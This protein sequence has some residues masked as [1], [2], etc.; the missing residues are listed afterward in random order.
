MCQC[1][2]VLWEYRRDTGV[3]RSSSIWQNSRI[4]IEN[5]LD[6]KASQKGLAKGEFGTFT[7]MEKYNQLIFIECNERSQLFNKPSY[8]GY[9]VNDVDTTK[10]SS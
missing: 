6:G 7:L 2:H 1:R 10:S 5:P 9:I 4:L 3:V 8:N